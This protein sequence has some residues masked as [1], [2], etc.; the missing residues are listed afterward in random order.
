MLRQ[1]LVADT[2]RTHRTTQRALEKLTSV[3]AAD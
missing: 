3:K 2:N 1:D